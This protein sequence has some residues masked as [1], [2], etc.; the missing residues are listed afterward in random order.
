[1]TLPIFQIDAFTNATFGG[2]P[3]AVIPLNEWLSDEKLQQIAM[4]NNLSETVFLRKEEERYRIRWFTPTVEV[5]LCGHA[6]VAAAHYLYTITGH[7]GDIE[8]ISR[9][10]KLSV[11][12]LDNWLYLDFPALLLEPC[13]VSEE[14]VI[15]MGCRPV[16]V[17]KSIDDLQ[18]LYETEAEILALDPDFGLLKKFP[19]RGII[20]TAKSTE[21][22][23]DFVSRFFAPASGVN[24][25]PVTGS[26]HTK[27]IPYWAKRLEKM[28]MNAKQL[29]ARGGFL[30]CSLKNDRVLIGGQ[31]T[32]YL[33]GNIYI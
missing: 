2:N 21:K 11:S 29:S 15:A 33:V 6:T 9:S 17:Q 16:E 26:A 8:F 28:T 14:L 10:G 27:L 7:H 4:E 31:A 24:E 22:G 1:M 18:L 30:R 3:A 32:L 25:D 13:D 23:I 20:A 5:D 19:A 12:T